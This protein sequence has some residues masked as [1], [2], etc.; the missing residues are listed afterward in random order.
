MR[1]NGMR[2]NGINNISENVLTAYMKKLSCDIK[3]SALWTTYSMLKTMIN[4]KNNIDI[5]SYPKLCSFLKLKSTGYKTKK[6]KILTPEQIKH[7]LLKA[8]YREY[9]FTKLD[10]RIHPGRF[11][12]TAGGV[13]R[14]ICES[15]CK[16]GCPPNFISAIGDDEQGRLLKS[17]IP[18]ESSGMVKVVN[19]HSTAQ[20]VI[21]FDNKGECKFLMGD[22]EIHKEITPEE[23]KSQEDIIQTSP[24]IILDGNLSTESIGESLRLAEKYSIPVSTYTGPRSADVTGKKQTR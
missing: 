7:F 22:M 23:I 11:S 20:C 17:F 10:G 2:P 18:T 6:S 4:I 3:P 24:L 13:A 16:L 1:P 14:N 15:L 19:G 9:L 12:Y 21:V 8:P 5:S